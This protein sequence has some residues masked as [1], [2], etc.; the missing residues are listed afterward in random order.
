M[1]FFVTYATDPWGRPIVTHVSWGA[2]W[3]SAFIGL[4]FLIAHSVY[5]TLSANRKHNKANLNA[6]EAKHPNLPQHITRHTLMARLFH[7]VMAGA[8]FVLLVTAFFPILGVQ[9]AWVTWHWMAGLVL[10]ASIIYH[11]VH[12]TFWL[13][14]WSIWV[15]PGDI[16]EFK[17]EMLREAGYDVPGPKPAKY[18]LGN[19]LY[20]LVLVIVSFVIIGTGVVMLP[21]ID[22]PLL[23]RN[24]YFFTDV[25][26]GYIYV[27][28]GLVGVSLVGLT[29][30]HVYFAARP[31]KWWITK[32]MIFGWITRR[33]YLQHHEPS[34]WP[35]NQDGS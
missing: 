2:V 19:R 27:I 4:T 6:L 20:H 18:P 32:A 28:H 8:M 26:W 13:D 1:D 17:A 34:R 14:F 33:Q 15:G 3:V 10:T 9:F 24:P 11:I 5:M 25:T 31:E 35:V 23:E 29:I 21:R 22:T 16:P 12:V 30:A 7:W